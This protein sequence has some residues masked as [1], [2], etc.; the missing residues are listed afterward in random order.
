MRC[1][2]KPHWNRRLLRRKGCFTI[3]ADATKLGTSRSDLCVAGGGSVY[4]RRLVLDGFALSPS[5]SNGLAFFAADD[6]TG[7]YEE[8]ARRIAHSRGFSPDGRLIVYAAPGAGANLWLKQ[9]G[10]GPPFQITKEQWSDSSPI[11][12]PDGQQIA[13]ISNRGGQLGVWII[14]AFGGTPNLIKTIETEG[15]SAPILKNWDRDGATVFYEWDH[16]FYSLSLTTGEIAQ[17]TNFDP[18]VRVPRAFRLSPDGLTIAYVESRKDQDDIWTVDRR[19]GAP[20][21]VTDDPASDLVPV[22][23]PDGKRLLYTSERDGVESICVAYLDGGQPEQILF[24]DGG[25]SVSDISTDGSK[26]LYYTLKDEIDLW[27]VDV[28]SGQERQIT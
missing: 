9:V 20:R 1:H 4:D 6:P 24:E 7:E 10:G 18:D 3:G 22:W 14:P 23:H 16:N 15:K 17:V 11:W 13:F 26:I 8:Y 19:G 28:E 21:R 2:P 27:E 25:C 5:L 12:S